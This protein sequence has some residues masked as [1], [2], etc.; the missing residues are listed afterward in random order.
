MLTEKELLEIKRLQEVCELDGGFQLKL[1][2][3]MLENR[4]EDRQEDFFHYEGDQLVGFLGSYCWGSRVELCGM[5]H[6]D[7]RRKGIFSSLLKLGFDEAKKRDTETILLNA[8]TESQSAKEFLKTIP[9]NFTV[10]EYQMQWQP[11]DLVED[12]TVT[13][14]AS[15]S[16][17]DWEAEIQLEIS[18]FGMTEKQA[19]E[20]QQVISENSSDH[21]LI[22]EVDGRI[23][24]K[25]RVSELNGEAWIYGFTVFPE[26]RGKG[27]GRKALTK[28]V[29]MELQKGLP[30]F[31][32]V[33]A[34][35]AHALGL[36]ESCGFKT[37]HSQDY[38]LH[39][40]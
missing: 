38:Y 5:V 15:S 1:N 26:L 40:E 34:K 25:M 20:M 4:S 36:Y 12:N 24:G 7:S 37:Y 17:E 29:K 3:D 33:E 27:I 10:A 23:A 6:P 8:P 39:S 32:E 30:I 14:R 31:L 9:C 19:E 2:F 18:G 28:V 16:K 22:I 35:N 21:R 11:T 13:V